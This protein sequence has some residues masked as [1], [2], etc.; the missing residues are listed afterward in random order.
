VIK[1]DMVVCL[2]CDLSTRLKEESVNT[3]LEA[4]ARVARRNKEGYCGRMPGTK[5]DIQKSSPP[6][7][8]VWMHFWAPDRSGNG[9]GG[10]G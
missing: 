5:S 8:P 1:T 9:G 6:E 4:L 7:M 3:I 10:F 2:A